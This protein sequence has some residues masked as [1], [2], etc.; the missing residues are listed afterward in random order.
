M[1]G[2]QLGIIVTLAGKV[3]YQAL[4]DLDRVNRVEYF[5]KSRIFQ[6]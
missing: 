4:L 1:T 2:L 5:S 3:G 6:E